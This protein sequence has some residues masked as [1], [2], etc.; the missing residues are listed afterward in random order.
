[1]NSG[2][3]KTLKKQ[4]SSAGIFFQNLPPYGT[5]FRPCL[6]KNMNKNGLRDPEKPTV[7]ELIIVALKDTAV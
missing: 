4:P 5:M 6:G 3:L 7:L 2:P 1:M